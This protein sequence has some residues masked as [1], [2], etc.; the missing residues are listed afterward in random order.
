MRGWNPRFGT[1]PRQ[2]EAYGEIG[3]TSH[4]TSAQSSS[5]RVA[6]GGAFFFF[7]SRR[8][9]TRSLRDWSSDV[10]SSDLTSS[11]TPVPVGGLTSVA[12]VSGGGSHTCAL[13]GDGTVQCWGEN[14]DGQLGDGTT[15]SSSTPV[16]VVGITGAVAVASGWQ[17][18][19]ALL[20]DGTVQ[21]WG[22]NEFG[23]LGDG[24]TTSSS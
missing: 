7:S 3:R 18:T 23:Q 10:C 16:R 17:H 24:T 4:L 11:S 12:A 9:H 21:C 19:C 8:R 15:A 6:A 5:H 13:P 1:R 14:A 22:R 20:G 2:E